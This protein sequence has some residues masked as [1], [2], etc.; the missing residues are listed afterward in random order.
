MP[1]FPGHQEYQSEQESRYEVS[2]L[3]W[4][5]LPQKNKTEQSTAV[6]GKSV[7]HCFLQGSPQRNPTHD[8]TCEQTPRREPYVGNSRSHNQGNSE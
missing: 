5:T 2:R 6:T 3:L 4:S 7:S 8:M 1:S